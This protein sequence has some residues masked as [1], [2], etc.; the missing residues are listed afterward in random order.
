MKT[1]RIG[2][3]LD[4]KLLTQFR[5]MAKREK[6]GLSELVQQ[7]IRDMVEADRRSRE[8]ETTMDAEQV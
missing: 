5:A 7:Y 3:R 6:K 8:L 4:D 1:G 2:V